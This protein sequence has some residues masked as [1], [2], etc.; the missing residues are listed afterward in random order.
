MDGW[1]AMDNATLSDL[2]GGIYDC[3]L[4]RSR[5]VPML[6][7]LAGVFR[8][9]N[10]TI[11]RHGVQDVSFQYHWGT[12]PEWLQAYAERHSRIDPLLTIA[13]H[14][15]VDEP[16]TVERFMTAAELRQTQF[17]H[18]FLVPLNWFDFVAVILEKSATQ[19]ST[20]G[21]TKPESAGPPD[22]EEKALIRRLAP[23]IRR[24][25]LFHAAMERDAARALDLV[26]AL[27]LLRMPVLLIDAAGSC[28][29][30]NAA[31]ERFLADTDALHWDRRAIRA[32]DPA[33]D[34]AF[35]GHPVSLGLDDADGRKFA[36][37][38]LPLTGGLRDRMGGHGRAVSAMFI[39]A[40][41]DLQPLPGEVLVKLYGLTPAETRLIGLLARGHSVDETAAALGI[42]RS[43]ARTHLRRVFEKTGTA[44]QTQ[45]MKL[46]MSALPAP[47]A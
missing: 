44:R 8:A 39:Q 3:A 24:A 43:T 36:V 38:V 4:D 15:E 29:E 34:V 35:G 5:W 45:L 40:V 1:L 9:S 42:A 27:N 13:W 12:P 18:D 11:L 10:G 21:F 19:S 41:G 23:H 7:H 2:I 31:A 46:V 17:Y 14:F 28:V 25:T 30:L 33:K 37:H 26:E 32:R 16:I 6:E 47:P 22:E 20:V